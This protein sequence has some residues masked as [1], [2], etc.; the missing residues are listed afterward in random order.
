M[1][2]LAR[3]NHG[4]P[5]TIYRI[6]GDA[7]DSLAFHKFSVFA[8]ISSLFTSKAASAFRAT[9]H[10]ELERKKRHA[11]FVRGYYQKRRR[12]FDQFGNGE[13][14]LER[15]LD[16]VEGRL[17]FLH[18]PRTVHTISDARPPF[19]PPH[20]TGDSAE[21]LVAVPLPESNV[22]T[23]EEARRFV[24]EL[25]YDARAAF[26]SMPRP[27]WMNA[28]PDRRRIG[29]VEIEDGQWRDRTT[30][31]QPIPYVAA[32]TRHTTQG[33]LSRDAVLRAVAKMRTSDKMRFAVVEVVFR[34]QSPTKIAKKFRL[35]LE[36]LKK[37]STRIRKRISDEGENGERSNEIEAFEGELSTLYT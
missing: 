7:D 35:N 28:K 26:A 2:R 32:A 18:Q 25:G 31:A 27:L 4:Y 16:L 17:F 33:F 30:I 20:W 11:R 10:N 5:T 6:V 15:L 14:E 23:L 8:F 36:T 29:V 13:R 34:R 37:Y 12:E 3:I 21:G 22:L 9:L 24:S 1:N 19:N